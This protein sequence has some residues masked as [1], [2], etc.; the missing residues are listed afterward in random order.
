MNPL[1]IV[2]TNPAQ[3]ISYQLGSLSSGQFALTVIESGRGRVE[4]TPREN[5]FQNGEVVT[6][7]A[8]PET[9]QD[10]IGWSGHASGTSTQIVVTMN[11]SKVITANFTKRPLLRD[12]TPLEGLVEDGFRFTLLGEFGEPY[13]LLTSTNLFDWLPIGTVTN[14]FGTIQFTDPAGTNLPWRFY[15]AVRE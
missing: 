9:A 4:V 7:T 8:L 15:R 14:T 10:F 1:S 11:Q 5:R 2:A 13:S 3:S 6:L 12:N